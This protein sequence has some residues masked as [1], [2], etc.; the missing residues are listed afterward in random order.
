MTSSSGN[1]E[2][3]VGNNEYHLDGF[4]AVEVPGRDAGCPPSSRLPAVVPKWF[5]RSRLNQIIE[6][7]NLQYS[8]LLQ[9]YKCASKSRA[10][11]TCHC[12]LLILRRIRNSTGKAAIRGRI[13]AG[14]ASRVVNKVSVTV[15]VVVSTLE[16]EF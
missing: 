10:H 4:A 3:E 16:L 7:L 8:R 12:Y 9:P 2:N 13:C 14:V 11:V 5:S 6:P 15:N 1:N